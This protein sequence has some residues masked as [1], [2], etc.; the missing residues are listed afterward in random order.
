MRWP[1]A[2]AA[3]FACL[4]LS[5]VSVSQNESKPA[6]SDA[7]LT[8][9]QLAIYRV[10]LKNYRKDDTSPMNLAD[11]TN[12]FHSTEGSSELACINSIKGNAPSVVHRISNAAV[13]GPALVLVDP[14]QLNKRGIHDHQN[15]TDRNSGDT[16]K[17]AFETGLFTLSEIVFDKEHCHA[18]VAYSFVC[19]GLCGNG[20]TLVLRRTGQMWKVTKRCGGWIS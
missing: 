12:P 19:G 4:T 16:I 17:R 11:R 2:V 18:V 6:V 9:E 5:I 10:V 7:P 14:Q 8:A 13:L 3:T 15:V 1:F 20:G